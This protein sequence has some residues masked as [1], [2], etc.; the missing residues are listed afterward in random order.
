M[1]QKTGKYV[2]VMLLTSIVFST[3]LFADDSKKLM[4][5]EI[6]E[7]I[8]EELQAFIKS[9]PKN[10]PFPMD[11]Y[12]AKSRKIYKKYMPNCQ[13][14]NLNP[15]E[16]YHYASLLEN[17][18]DQSAAI[19]VYSKLAKGSGKIA[20]ES[21]ERLLEL[22]IENENLGI[23]EK[24]KRISEFRSRFAPS[25][26]F[27]SSLRRVMYK[28]LQL[29]R[30]KN[31]AN[32]KIEIILDELAYLKPE[33]TSYNWTLL[34]SLLDLYKEI[35][36]ADEGRILVDKYHSKLNAAYT[37]KK[38]NPPKN[39]NER[40]AHEGSLRGYKY[41]IEQIDN[42]LFLDGL[43]GKP[44]PGLNLTHFYN[45]EPFNFE[46][47]KGKVVVLDFFANWCGPCVA[48]FPEMRKLHADYKNKGLMLIGVT[49]FQKSMT[50]HGEDPVKDLSREAEAELMHKF[51][52]Y[53]NVTWPGVFSDRGCYD[54]EYGVLGIPTI[55]VIDKKGDVRTIGN[56]WEMDKFITLI[57]KLLAE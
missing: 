55:A 13:T 15:D 1:D 38:N 41:L 27:G 39:P 40:R 57:E 44:A 25:E 48:S 49:G 31:N 54:P 5:S 16:S 37:A 47:T 35:G 52:K 2:L 50:N 14:E 26:E 19:A 43:T 7:L 12:K 9:V 51:I 3:T 22:D 46:N 53:Q 6:R 28:L 4:P 11:E 36:K 45:T 42:K 20:R 56:P 30:V 21:S 23:S 10:K 33:I 17:P 34:T 32:L 18:D 29:E 24:R 8:A